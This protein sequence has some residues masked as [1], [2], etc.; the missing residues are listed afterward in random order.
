MNLDRVTSGKN[1]PDEVNV[2]VEIPLH[3]APVKYE[4]DKESGAMFVDRFLNT[5][6]HYPCNY[7][8]IPK[9]L[10]KDGD[11]IDVIIMTPMPLIHG[12]VIPCRPIGILKMTDEAGDDSK[13]MVVPLDSVSRFQRNVN[14]YADVQPALLDQITH[15]FEHYKDLEPNKWVKVD[16]W[17]DVDDARSEIIEAMDAY[18]SSSEE[19]HY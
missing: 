8:Y 2:I 19:L 12:S 10:A 11:P 16:G 14:S 4:L 6:M 1:P 5:S 9:T 7:G 3:G 18:S 15:F 17:S 13:I